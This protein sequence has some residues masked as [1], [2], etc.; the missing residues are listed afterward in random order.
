MPR[1]IVRR[2]LAV[3]VGAL[4]VLAALSVARAEDNVP[5]LDRDAIEIVLKKKVSDLANEKD[6]DGIGYKRGT[7]SK[8]FK[9]VDAKT[10]LVSFHVGTIEAEAQPSTDQ[11]RTER[12]ELTLSKGNDGKWSITKQELKD[13]YIGLYRGYIGG[14]WVY[15]FSK[16][17]FEK[18]GLKVSAT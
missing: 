14:E 15:S 5:Y 17:Q 1:L 8:S 3:L 4:L 11:V 13:T 7:Y 10:Y 12:F 16:L 6:K 9:K 18:E 2:F